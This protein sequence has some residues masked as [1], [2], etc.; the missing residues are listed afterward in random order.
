MSVQAYRRA[1]SFN[2]SWAVQA[3]SLLLLQ[4]IELAGTIW[5]VRDSLKEFPPTD[6]FRF[7][8][9][10]ARNW[11]PV[12][13]AGAAFLLLG[14]IASDVL[15]SVLQVDVPGREAEKLG[16]FRELFTAGDGITTWATCLVVFVITPY[17]EELVY[18][19]F[20]LGSL[21]GL[22]PLPVAL[23]ISALAFAAGHLTLAGFPTLF[24]VGSVLGLAYARTENLATSF[25]IHSLYNLFLIAG[26]LHP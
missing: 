12:A 3:V 1:A 8:L 7:S 15:L 20:L 16:A 22:V 24:V 23:T 26:L 2:C 25:T 9:R 5:L 17:M 19:G 10:G 4:S 18:R 14:V 21:K 13:G 11:A 6:Q